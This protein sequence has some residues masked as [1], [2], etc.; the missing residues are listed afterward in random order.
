MVT[1]TV[2]VGRNNTFSLQLRRAEEPIN[3]LA[4]TGYELHLSNGRMFSDLARFVEKQNGIVE[5]SIGD[6]LAVTDV[7]TQTAYLVTV[8]PINTAGVRW[9]NFKLRVRA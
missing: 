4:I 5:I 6:L 3:L 9:P 7:G 2:F 1:E 8:D